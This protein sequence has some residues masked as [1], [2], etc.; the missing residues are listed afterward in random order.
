[1]PEIDHLSSQGRIEEFDLWSRVAGRGS[2][3][4][5][6]GCGSKVVGGKNDFA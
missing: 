1:M 2:W 6:R 4:V 5:R 3:V